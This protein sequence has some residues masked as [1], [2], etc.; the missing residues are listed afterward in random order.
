MDIIKNPRTHR[1]ARC[2]QYM[3]GECGP[4]QPTAIPL[5]DAGGGIADPSC[6]F[7]LLLI[8]NNPCSSFQFCLLLR[9]LKHRPKAFFSL[10]KTW[11]SIFR[12]SRHLS[13]SISFSFVLP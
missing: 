4:E 3:R 12:F 6:R 1:P 5:T 9:T 8:G 2:M 13:S 11:L 10:I 7:H